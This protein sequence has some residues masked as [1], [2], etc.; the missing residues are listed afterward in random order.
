MS[1]KSFLPSWYL[2]CFSYVN[3]YT[4]LPL[5]AYSY[6]T[7]ASTLIKTPFYI[8]TR[9]GHMCPVA[10]YLDLISGLVALNTKIKN[11]KGFSTSD[12][13]RMTRLPG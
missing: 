13:A 1:V 4:S 9:R 11:E 8:R 7:K 2:C 12:K 6:P 3:I 5:W 10:T